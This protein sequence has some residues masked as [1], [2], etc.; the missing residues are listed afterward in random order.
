MG[1]MPLLSNDSASGEGHGAGRGLCEQGWW[2]RGLTQ[3]QM[4]VGEAR[5]GMEVENTSQ[6]N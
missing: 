1:E 4:E 2:Q 5:V 3:Y 6:K